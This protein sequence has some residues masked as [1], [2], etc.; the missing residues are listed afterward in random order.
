MIVARR[1]LLLIGALIGATAAAP[2]DDWAAVT[3]RDAQA[4]HDAI[5]A[6]HPG[7][8]NTLD[9]GFRRRNAAGLALAIRR[10]GRVRSYG[11]YVAA[12]RGYVATFDDGH[13]ALDLSNDV[14]LPLAW[15]GFLTGFD[16]TGAQVVRTTARD[17]DLPLG[18]TLRQCDGVPAAAL[19]QRNVGAFRGRWQL[20]SQR[21]LNGGRL[22]IDAGNPFV[23]RPRRCVFTIA[24]KARAVD[25]A[26]RPLPDAA[27]DERFATTSQRARPAFASKTLD[28]GTRWYGLPSFD[29]DPAG[30]AAKALGPMIARLRQ[31]RAA[32]VTAPRI[33]LDL[34]G[35]G[36]GSSDWSRQ[37]A[38][39]LWGEGAV[40][41]AEAHATAVDWRASPG[42]L[43][44]MQAYRDHWRDAPDVSAEARDW[45]TRTAAGLAG[46]L[47]RGQPLWREPPEPVAGA[48]AA[49]SAAASRPALP[50]VFVLTDWG[51]ASACLD[52]VDLWTALGARQIGQETSADSLYMEVREIAMPSGL[53]SAVV[54]MKVY[55]GRKRG[56]NVPAIP[57]IRY[58]GDMRDGAALERWVLALGRR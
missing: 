14:A 26:W 20:E 54:P 41:M 12:M 7:P 58:P 4:F 42:N 22:F 24:G 47:K 11:G 8:Y 5:A 50:P 13:V 25:L 53:G 17:V 30:T 10:A 51:C 37:I 52:A 31:D 1:A 48:V 28:D 3:R 40:A 32:I 36:G 18:A 57:N 6:N 23:A 34:R 39:I 45:A 33:V 27:F 44:A 29:G 19:A 15:P 55:R 56:S 46:A 49:P 38:V 21:A 43:A 2:I 9:R 16:A 35:N